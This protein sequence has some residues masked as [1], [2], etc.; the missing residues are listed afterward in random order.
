MA[1]PTV[2]LQQGLDRVVKF[3]KAVEGPRKQYRLKQEL[4]S[5]MG[6]GFDRNELLDFLLASHSPEWLMGE[7]E[8]IGHL[9]TSME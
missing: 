2:D 8:N 6:Y 5:L 3:L 4:L 1:S 7:L 9:M